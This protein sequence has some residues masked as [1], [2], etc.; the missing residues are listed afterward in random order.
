MMKSIYP[1]YIDLRKNKSSQ[2]VNSAIIRIKEEQD[3]VEYNLM[4]YVEVINDLDLLDTAFYEQIKYGSSD[5]KTI[6]LLKNGISMELAKVL[7]DSKYE[8][9]LDFDLK[10]DHV[11]IVK[12]A[13]K[14]MK[15][16]GENQVLIFELQFHAV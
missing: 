13:V 4:K 15:D 10:N 1:Q 12:A 11:K 3:F 6:C 5:P 14:E 8:E 16:V 9:Y 7:L 2:R